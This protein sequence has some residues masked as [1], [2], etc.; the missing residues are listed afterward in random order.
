M[1]TT[2]ARAELK[3]EIVEYATIATNGDRA[4]VV[5]TLTFIKDCAD[6]FMVGSEI[7]EAVLSFSQEH[8]AFMKQAIERLNAIVEQ[9]VNAAN[10]AAEA[11]MNYIDEQRSDFY[12]DDFDYDGVEAEVIIY[13]DKIVVQAIGFQEGFS[14]TLPKG[15]KYQGNGT[16]RWVYP[17]SKRSEFGQTTWRN[18]PVFLASP[19]CK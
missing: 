2:Q 1:D 12:Q 15:G 6:R 3:A 13:R 8:R 19:E 9:E 4:K 10:A 14:K 7:D 5:H 16:G 17:L 18:N 11:E